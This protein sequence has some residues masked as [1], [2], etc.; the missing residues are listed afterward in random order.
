MLA[1]HIFHWFRGDSGCN[2]T[3]A[4]RVRRFHRKVISLRF[5][6][7]IWAS[8]VPTGLQWNSA[9]W[10]RGKTTPT[11]TASWWTFGIFFN[12][13]PK[14]TGRGGIGFFFIEN[15]RGGGGSPTRGGGEGGR[16]GVCREWGGG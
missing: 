7:A 6:F 14:A 4:L 8:K 10:K 15:P 9:R 12:F 13:F 5:R 3:G 16:E 11:S 1:A 2:F